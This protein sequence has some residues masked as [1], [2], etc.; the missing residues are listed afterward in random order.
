MLVF[1]PLV[2]LDGE[3]ALCYHRSIGSVVRF[4]LRP[5]LIDLIL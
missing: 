2:R 4:H 1:S 3:V 5:E